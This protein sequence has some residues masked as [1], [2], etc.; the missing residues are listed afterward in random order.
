M[1]KKKTRKEYKNLNFKKTFKLL[2][3]TTCHRKIFKFR[4]VNEFK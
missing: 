1:E 3:T 2:L 4:N